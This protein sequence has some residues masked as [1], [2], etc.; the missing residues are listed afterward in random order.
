[1]LANAASKLR[2]KLEFFTKGRVVD[3]GEMIRVQF[4]RIESDRREPVER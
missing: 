4:F 2:R 1:M 3:M